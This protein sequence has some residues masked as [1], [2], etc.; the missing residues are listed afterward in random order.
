MAAE[1]IEEKSKE[2]FK[3]LQDL[4]NHNLGIRTRVAVTTF[5]L[6]LFLLIPVLRIFGIEMNALD[7][8]MV[9]LGEFIVMLGIGY[10]AKESLFRT[11][12]NRL[13]FAF[14]LSL[15][16]ILAVVGCIALFV[17]GADLYCFGRPQPSV[18]LSS[19]PL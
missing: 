11:R 4:S 15:F 9:S 5:G 19:T 2:D 1:A 12:I 17:D 3:K 8:T 7:V 10:W 13:H 14:L 6:A 16:L 18:F